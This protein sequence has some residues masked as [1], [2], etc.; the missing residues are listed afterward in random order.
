LSQTRPVGRVCGF[1][2]R[3]L[4][5]LTGGRFFDRINQYERQNTTNTENNYKSIRL[6]L[7][8]YWLN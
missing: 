3:V 7:S 8:R 2:L 5:S 1:T 4:I 6:G